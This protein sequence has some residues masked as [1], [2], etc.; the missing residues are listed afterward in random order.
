MDYQPL[1]GFNFS[2]LSSG[3]FSG[4]RK[5]KSA[6][7]QMSNRDPAVN[8]TSLTKEDRIS[9]P[10]QLNLDL[11]TDLNIA[12]DN[13]AK[14]KTSP[15]FSSNTNLS[16]TY[17]RKSVADCDSEIIKKTSSIRQEEPS[18]ITNEIGSIKQERLSSMTDVVQ[19]MPSRVTQDSCNHAE[20]DHEENNILTHASYNEGQ[21]DALDSVSRISE[22]CNALAP[23][24]Q[25]TENSHYGRLTST[26]QLQQ[27]VDEAA[28]KSGSH[29]TSSGRN[30][31]TQQLGSQQ[32][33]IISSFTNDAAESDNESYLG[34]VLVAS[35]S[36]I[37][38]SDSSE[39]NYSPNETLYYNNSHNARKPLLLILYILCAVV[40]YPILMILVP[41]L[42]TVKVVSL[43]CCCIPCLRRRN[44]THTTNRH[45]NFQMFSSTR[46]GGYHTIGIE[47]K[48]RMDGERFVKCI[49]SK[50][51]DVYCRESADREH[52]KVFRL[53]S[54]IRWIAC[55]SWWELREN[56]K[57]EEHIEILNKRI[58]TTTNFTDFIEQLSKRETSQK[59]KLWQLYYIPFFKTKSSSLVLKVHHSLLSGISL[60][61]SLFH[62]F[63][64]SIDTSDRNRK[65]IRGQMPV[66]QP[67][68]FETVLAAP[69]VVLK[70]LLRPS[71]SLLIN[72]N[73]FRY[74]YSY[75]MY[76]SEAF[77]VANQCKVSLHS[78]FIAPLSQS[79]R[80]LYSQKYPFGRV[81]VAIPVT[82]EPSSKCQNSSTFLVNLPLTR[83]SWDS[84]RLQQFDKELYS[85]SK[86]AFVLLSAANLASL[87]LSPCTVDFLASSV[88]R[89]ADL[90]FQ[91]V[92]CPSEPHYLNDCAISS[93][94]YWP[95]LFRQ[96]SMGVCVVVYERSFRVCV[97][98]DYSVTGW[99]DILLKHYIANYSELYR[100]LYT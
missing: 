14:T 39:M 75:P 15:K 89:G 20:P 19:T 16:F 50:L 95:P 28:S 36:S 27:P 30:S 71:L 97:V 3:N 94:M 68:V 24:Q 82:A 69:C 72:S 51:N 57:L 54:V 93:V 74:A 46:P 76:A 55:F 70:H 29:S 11:V 31:K 61:D 42:L 13:S 18:E 96:I 34:S 53:A 17:V 62:I 65:F 2:L 22:S 98:T 52:N 26:D 45:R 99:P 1:E 47:L 66:C 59:R 90:L 6:S 10:G 60:K 79:L 64:D 41:F 100:S 73:K 81:R 48:E 78:L 4:E 44:K 38:L 87:T 23:Q 32:S 8:R 63:S 49:I 35:S 77:H 21:D 37:S 56:V 12:E 91:V 40:V 5:C 58:T 92:H 84:A 86:D 83:E 88:L 7:Q 9:L 33:L 80:R 25:G 67:N 85:N 43:L